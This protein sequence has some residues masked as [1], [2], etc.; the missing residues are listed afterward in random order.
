MTVGTWFPVAMF[1]A[2]E[3][4]NNT[5]SDVFAITSTITCLPCQCS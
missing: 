4:T 5:G 1:Q 3:A 2:K